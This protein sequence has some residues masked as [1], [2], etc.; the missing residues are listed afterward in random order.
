MKGLVVPATGI[1]YA[2]DLDRGGITKAVGGYP[3]GRGVTIYFSEQENYDMFVWSLDEEDRDLSALPLNTRVTKLLR[4]PQ[5]ETVP[6]HG[7][8]VFT[9]AT[10]DDKARDISRFEARAILRDIGEIPT[11]YDGAY[12]RVRME[13]LFLDGEL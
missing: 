13:R 9:G 2:T 8:V 11:P 10:D 1:A 4:T 6:F 7:T 3:R 12:R 5:G